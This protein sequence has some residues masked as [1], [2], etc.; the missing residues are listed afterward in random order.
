MRHNLIYQ[1]AALML[2][3]FAFIM[4]ARVS[5]SVFERL[6]HLEDELAYLF[7]A[8]VFANGDV[9]AEIPDNSRAY[10]QP[11]IINYRETLDNGDEIANR[12]G[13]Y[14][15]GWPLLLSLGIHMGGQLWVI[16]ALLSM[17]TVAVVYRIGREV[18]NADVG[19]IAAALT[20]FSPMALLLNA[21]LMAHTAA[22]FCITLFIWAYW[23]LTQKRNALRWGLVAGV[24]LGAM[25]AMRPLSAAATVLPF[26]LWSGTRLL[27]T[28]FLDRPQTLPTLYPLLAISFPAIIIS[29][30]TPWFNY[31][32]TGDPTHNLYRE[33]WDY[34]RVGFGEGYGRNGHTIIK[35]V[36]H[37]RYD[38]SLTS[39]DLFGWT[40]EARPQDAT[41]TNAGLDNVLT[42]PFRLTARLLEEAIR[43]RPGSITTD[44]TLDERYDAHFTTSARYLP[45]VVGMGVFVVMAG[46]L[47]GF[48]RWWLWLLA[49]M[50]IA[51]F[52]QPVITDAS[53][54]TEQ[55]DQVWQWV[56]VGIGLTL[57]QGVMLA[58]RPEEDRESTWTWLLFMVGFTLIVA[59]L[60]YWVGSQRYSTRYYFEALT[61]F[62]LLGGVALSWIVQQA[63][64]LHPIIGVSIAYIAFGGLLLWSLLGYSQPRISVLYQFNYV[65]AD[66]IEKVDARRVD[67][68]PILV[69]AELAP[70]GRNTWRGTGTLMGLTDPYFKSDM[71]VAWN[72]AGTTAHRQRLIDQHPGRQVIDITYNFESSWFTNC[73]PGAVIAADVPVD[74]L[75]NPE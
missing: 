59:H 31:T 66:V 63:R 53:F 4:A 7:Q 44:G 65:T 15:P 68:A 56:F 34:D 20:A 8:R 2:A 58:L 38:L 35:G 51:W 55:A 25:L 70:E 67:D 64:R 1:I 62:C 73:A 48:R 49:G 5:D 40:I 9:V 24:A 17:L 21:T 42:Y 41:P 10:W 6:P 50:V 12:V 60:A 74:C 46:V 43:W 18:Y 32:V 54:L 13:K 33:V 75:L 19:L 61:A 27:R 11:F 26:V 37:T 47:V 36:S 23:R 29:L 45:E 39:A 14:A 28:F 16:N 72:Y 30:M 57:L 69:I 71:I 52:A 22:L 3:L